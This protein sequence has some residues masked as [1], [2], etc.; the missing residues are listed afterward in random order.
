MT[1][2]ESESDLEA[3]LLRLYRKWEVLGYRASRFYQMFMPHCKQLPNTRSLEPPNRFMAR[4]KNSTR[5]WPMAGN[6]CG[7]SIRGR[8]FSL[9][10]LGVIARRFRRSHCL[11]NKLLSCLFLT[12]GA[13]AAN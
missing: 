10:G 7:P 1:D 9:G 8:D 6:A 5:F 13:W 3:L 2:L 12:V 4:F 11:A